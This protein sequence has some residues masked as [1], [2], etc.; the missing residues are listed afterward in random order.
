[1]PATESSI[2]ALIDLATRYVAALNA[3]DNDAFLNCFR[4]NCVVRDPYGLSIYHGG[5]E[6]RQYIRTMIDTWRQYTL[7][8]QTFIAGGKDRVVFGWVVN[9]VAQD[10]QPVEFEG[11][12]VLTIKE[13][14]I[15]GLESY[16]DARAMFAQLHP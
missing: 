9:A 7:T 3:L 1:M 11:I 13:G 12:T 5:D 16:Y 15:D 8:P 6:L 14:L 10:G 4:A 2:N